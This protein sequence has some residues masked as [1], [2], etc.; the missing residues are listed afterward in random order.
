MLGVLCALLL[1]QAVA[2]RGGG[3]EI[4]ASPSAPATTSAPTQVD[5]Y[6]P[7]VVENAARKRGVAWQ[8]RDACSMD[9]F[10][11]LASYYTYGPFGYESPLPFVPQL[12]GCEDAQVAEFRERLERDWAVV[13]GNRESSFLPPLNADLQIRAT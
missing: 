3:P 4:T 5:E 11:G 10:A 2:A 13:G 12:W 9:V 7:E 6:A 1:T 8:M